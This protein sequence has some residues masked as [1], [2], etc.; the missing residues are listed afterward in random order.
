MYRMWAFYHEKMDHATHT[1][2]FA[3]KLICKKSLI[4]GGKKERQ[5]AYSQGT[6]GWAAPKRARE[7]AICPRII[8]GRSQ[9]ELADFPAVFF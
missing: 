8:V 1:A 9:Q 4:F 2:F 7:R 5:L 3:W 6:E